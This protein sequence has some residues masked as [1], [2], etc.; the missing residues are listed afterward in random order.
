MEF[1]FQ[2]ILFSGVCLVRSLSFRSLTRHPPPYP[3][4]LGHSPP[5]SSPIHPTHRPAHK[6]S[7]Y[8]KRDVA[9]FSWERFPNLISKEGGLEKMTKTLVYLKQFSYFLVLTSLLFPTTRPPPT[10]SKCN[11]NDFNSFINI[12]K[13]VFVKYSYGVF[14]QKLQ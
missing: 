12:S 10:H 6:I 14:S 5:F 9:L 2:K 4:P 7:K 11:V 1:I 3:L 8:A 13:T